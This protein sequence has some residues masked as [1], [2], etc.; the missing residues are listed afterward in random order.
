MSNRKTTHNG[1]TQLTVIWLWTV[2]CC[3]LGFNAP[4][5]NPLT[6]AL[7]V[8]YMKPSFMYIVQLE[9]S[10]IE[11]LNQHCDTIIQVIIVAP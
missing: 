2:S 3:L 7:V 6:C 11:K 1:E 5:N 9:M 10:N 4:R 8:Y